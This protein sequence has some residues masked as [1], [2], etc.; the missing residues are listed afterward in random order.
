MDR[1]QDG[2]SLVSP[3]PVPTTVG[4]GGFSAFAAWLH[5]YVPHPPISSQHDRWYEWLHSGHVVS[6]SSGRIAV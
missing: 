6:G 3:H 2:H 1:R 5:P 4:G